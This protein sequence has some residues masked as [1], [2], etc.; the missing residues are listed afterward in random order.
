MI[1]KFEH[2]Q[3]DWGGELLCRS[4]GS[5][6]LHQDRIEVFERGED[7]KHGVHVVV[8]NMKASVDSDFGGN[9]S[10][11]REGLSIRFWCEGCEA[12]PLLT[13]S[14]HKGNTLVDL[15]ISDQ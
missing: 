15:R 10:K 13:I 3:E 12:K 14:Q 5:N 6:Y 7:Q 11:R 4:C 8:E 9:P 2:Y 1:P